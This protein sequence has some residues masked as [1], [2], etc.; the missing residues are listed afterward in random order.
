[1]QKRRGLG[2]SLEKL[3]STGS[4]G[5]GTKEGQLQ[6]LPI[7]QLQR[8]AYQPRLDFSD[9]ALAELAQSIKQQ[10]VMQPLLVRALSSDRYEI[11]AGERRW[12]AA[13][14]AE[15]T[16]VPAIIRCVND[17][18]AL[19]MALI[20]NIQREDLHALEEAQA[21]ARLQQEFDLTHEQIAAAVGKSRTTVSNLLRLL[22]LSSAVK[23]LLE[24]GDLEMGHARALLALAPELQKSVA[25]MICEKGWS[26]R[27]A[28][29]Y[30]RQYSAKKPASHRPAAPLDLLKLQQTL[31]DRL[32]T[33]VA[34]QHRASGRGKMFIEYHSLSELDG[35]LQF[36]Q[37][38]AL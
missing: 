5:S 30:I 15:L 14:L 38:E 6:Y 9:S 4:P 23:T 34:F 7:D 13:Q 12:R 36:F 8:G 16:E 24:R 21:L 33:K 19:A 26:V 27:Q 25:Q 32:G 10:G 2:T 3:L 20:E 37:H 18:T 17:E 11:I 29:N 35:I 1:M 31:S 28:E 22:D